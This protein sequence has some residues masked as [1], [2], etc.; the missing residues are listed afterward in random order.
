M[1][2]ALG[3]VVIIGFKSWEIDDWVASACLFA[4]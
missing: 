4:W 3:L 1:T 2:A